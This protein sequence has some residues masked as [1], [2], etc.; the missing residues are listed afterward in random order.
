MSTEA[1]E[2][3]SFC[4]DVYKF[5]VPSLKSATAQE[6][7]HS[8]VL[9][10]PGMALLSLGRLFQMLQLQLSSTKWCRAAMA[11]SLTTALAND[12]CSVL[13]LQ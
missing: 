1:T 3:S 9:V 8:L 13:P 11:G 2:R 5:H 6:A 12:T 4:S 10:R 7:D